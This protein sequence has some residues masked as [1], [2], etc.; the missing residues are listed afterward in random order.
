LTRQGDAVTTDADFEVG[1]RTLPF[2]GRFPKAVP[3]WANYAVAPDCQPFVVA[4]QV[5]LNWFEELRQ[6]APP[7]E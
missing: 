3:N 4:R 5:V 1:R 2:A 7:G 6:K